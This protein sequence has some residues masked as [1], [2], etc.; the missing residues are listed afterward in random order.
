MIYRVSLLTLVSFF[1]Q[2]AIQHKRNGT[3]HNEH[4]KNRNPS[5]D[6]SLY[7]AKS[8]FQ[9]PYMNKFL[10]ILLVTTCALFT[11]SL[12][13]GDVWKCSK[14]SKTFDQDNTGKIC[15]AYTTRAG[16]TTHTYHTC[17]KKSQ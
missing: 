17:A 1:R 12:M 16:T 15:N 7:K 2:L 10:L 11:Q 3:H 14:C 5:N 8:F 6:Y 9:T 4:Y 13:A